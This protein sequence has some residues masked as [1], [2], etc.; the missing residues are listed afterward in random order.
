M[1]IGK[2]LSYTGNPLRQLLGFGFFVQG[3]RG[4]PW[5][6]VNFFL[7]DGLNVD[8][9]MLQLLQNSV[10]LPMVGKPLYGVVSDA[11]YIRGSIG[12]HTSPSEVSLHIC[13][14]VFI[15][16]F[17]LSPAVRGEG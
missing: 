9:S 14:P 8:P 6:G 2:M 5:M 11:V 12:F 3:F 4:F 16:F 17:P 15:F 1:V 7:K 10:N 13:F